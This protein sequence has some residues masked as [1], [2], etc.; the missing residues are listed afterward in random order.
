M[1]KRDYYH[2]LG[3]PRDAAPEDIK[4]AYR[5]LAL[6]HHPDR[7]PGSKEAEEKF[8]EAAEAYSVLAD[9]EKRSVYDRFGHDG[10]RGQGFSGLRLLR[11]RGLRG[12][13]R[14]ISSVSASATSSAAGRAAGAAPGAAGAATWPW[15]SRS[16][17]RRP[18][19]ASRRRS[20]S[21]GPR[22]ARPAAA[23][24]RK[25]GTP[26]VRLPDV[27]RAG[28]GPLP[29]GLLHHGQDLP[30]L[31]GRRRGQRLAVRIV[32]GQGPRPGEADPQGPHPGRRRRRLAAEARR[33][34]RG[35][36]RR[37]ARR[38]PLRR[39]PG[40]QASLLRARRE[41]PHLRDHRLV[42]PGR[43]RRPDRD[44]DPRRE[45]GPQ[46]PGRDPAGGDHPSQR[47]RASR[48]SP[49]AAR[50]TSSSR[51]SSGRPTTCPRSRRRSWP[52]SPRSAARTSTRSTRTSSTS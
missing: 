45:R 28:P 41:R 48:T 29:A 33:R 17:S 51:S 9:S 20:S 49:A 40:P 3:V 16:G 47:A 14:A 32:P 25:P 31:P 43:A 26:R 23:R 37:H 27:R 22:P 50:A 42:H 11:L 1:A 34:G 24:R 21:T 36:R 15:R 4:K 18:P 2:V 39:D 19:P 7:N 30:A 52:S 5:Q 35:R 10:L 13:P 46:G 6:K 8:K 44:P 12:H 38:R